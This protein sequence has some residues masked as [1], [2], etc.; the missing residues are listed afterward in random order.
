MTETVSP[1]VAKI[2]LAQHERFLRF[3]RSRV[4]SRQ[5]A[6]DIL[7]SSFVK[8][9]ERGRGIREDESVVAWFYRVLRNAIA[10]HHRRRSVEDRSLG[11]KK[12]ELEAADKQVANRQI[13]RFVCRCV[14]D[15]LATVKPE[16]ERALR[17]VDLEGQPVE[18]FAR[19][20]RITPNNAMVRLHRARKALHGRLLQSCGSCTEHGCLD[21]SCRD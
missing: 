10:D 19:A 7:Q 3:L 13:E 15:L 14:K 5:V 8:A 16:Y 2:L 11:K 6:E 4:K 1:A 17:R 12:A 18:D 20:E 9:L 21:C